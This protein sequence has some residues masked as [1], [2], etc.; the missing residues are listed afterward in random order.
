[1]D[2]IALSE[3]ALNSATFD[4]SVRVP[5]K[6]LILCATPRSG[7]YL[8]ARQLIRAGIGI[9]HEYVN[10]VNSSLIISRVFHGMNPKNVDLNTYVSWLEANRT[11]PNG[12]FA[13]KLHW[14]HLEQCP[15]LIDDWLRSPTTLC[16]FLY[17]RRL[18]SQAVSLQASQ[19]SG[20]WDIGGDISTRPRQLPGLSSSRE[21]DQMACRLVMWNGLWRF[22]F[23]A[24]GIEAI[25][26]AYEDFVADQ[27]N[28]IAA[29]AAK[30]SVDCVPPPPEQQATKAGTEM[31]RTRNEYLASWGRSPDDNAL[32]YTKRFI[33][34][35]II[36]LARRS[37]S[38]ARRLSK[39][40]VSLNHTDAT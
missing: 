21:T 33:L 40:I 30:L 20:V 38:R 9:P 4:Q 16:I 23:E 10:Q 39:R 37:A 12:V 5:A 22:L 36:D 2:R 13:A 1:M 3:N 8:L 7:S 25:E 34:G 28:T 19:R 18:L 24:N 17:R 29:I 27:S 11:T 15:S 31:H 6:R 35:E 32:G 14:P 26:L